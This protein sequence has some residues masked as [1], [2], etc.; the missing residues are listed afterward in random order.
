MSDQHQTEDS[1]ANPEEKSVE[2]TLYNSEADKKV[3]ESS[4]TPAEPV[5][6]EKP[7]EGEEG[8][9]EE[10]QIEFDLKLPEN[11]LLSDEAKDEIVSIAK[12]QGLSQDQAQKVLDLQ[13]EI[14]SE[15]S[16]QFTQDF[17]DQVNSW[18]EEIKADK[19]L[20]GDNL[21]KN[22]ELA[23]RAVVAFAGEEFLTEL[24]QTGY[25]NHPRLFKM[26][27]KIGAELQAGDLVLSSAQS[28][29]PKSAAQIMYPDK[30]N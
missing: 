25:A 9:V 3:E 29:Q 4:E 22:V 30:T 27:T 2:D 15:V 7:A 6:E 20:G 14:A 26:L 12:E 11:T 21:G 19:D 5:A 17:E 28:N 13:S 8:K 18:G 10:G 23:K 1:Q 24:D 16:D